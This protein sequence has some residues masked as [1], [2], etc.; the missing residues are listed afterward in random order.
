M[1]Y[2]YI[3][4]N[5][6]PEYAKY[7]RRANEERSAAFYQAFGALWRSLSVFGKV[8]AWLKRRVRE[9]AALRELSSLDDRS[10]KDIGISR[11][12]IPRIVKEF[13]AS[14]AD[15]PA[16]VD[17]GTAGPKAVDERKPSWLRGVLDGGRTTAHLPAAST[18]GAKD[19]SSDDEPAAAAH[20]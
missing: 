1:A 12:E 17:T 18:T 9:R 19:A 4:L 11:G 15:A 13:G 2:H 10:L 14:G 6:D 3:W 20:G 5:S 8:A 16:Q 7:L